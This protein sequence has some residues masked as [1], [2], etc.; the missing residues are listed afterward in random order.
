MTAKLSRLLV[1]VT[2]TIALMPG[3]SSAGSAES[4]ALAFSGWIEFSPGLS[5]SDGSVTFNFA[6]DVCFGSFLAGGA[7]L[8]VTG[9]TDVTC[10]M[11]M[12]GEVSGSCIHAQGSTASELTITNLT[13]DSTTVVLDLSVMIIGRELVLT[14]RA[15]TESPERSGPFLGAGLTEHFEG[16]CF[17]GTATLFAVQGTA[18][19][20]LL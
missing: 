10:A 8:P 20:A 13:G 2:M 4:G 9:V 5:L 7:D 17:D 18:T 11:P 15:I 12:T 1:A 16:N 6:H 3:T 19:Y 14:G